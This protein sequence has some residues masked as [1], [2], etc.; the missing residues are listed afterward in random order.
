MILYVNGVSNSFG[1]RAGLILANLEGI[2]AEYALQFIFHALYGVSNSFGS[3][4]GLILANLERI[5]A[6]YALQFIFHASNNQA[7]Y[8][9]L[10]ARLRIVK[11]LKAR[12]LGPS[13][14]LNWWLIR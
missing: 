8:E 4:A 1:N 13:Q 9:V 12:S 6:E 11:E 2:V 14:I 10:L 7:K 5:V 3:G